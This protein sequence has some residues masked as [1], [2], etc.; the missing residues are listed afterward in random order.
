MTDTVRRVRGHAHRLDVQTARYYP[1][2]RGD[3]HLSKFIFDERT[4]TGTMTM[5]AIVK[6]SLPAPNLS[7]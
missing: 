4:A 2:Y 6:C 3:T 7:K 1:D 5:R